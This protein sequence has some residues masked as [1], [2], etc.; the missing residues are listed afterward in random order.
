MDRCADGGRVGKIV[1]FR[2]GKRE[3]GLA[4]AAFEAYR[5]SKLWRGSGEEAGK[6]G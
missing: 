6:E 5:G 4:K 1:G 3:E 2:L